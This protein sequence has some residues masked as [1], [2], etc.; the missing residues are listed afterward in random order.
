MK[1]FNLY[2]NRD[3]VIAISNGERALILYTP[4]DYNHHEYNRVGHFK[5]L[6]FLR[7]FEEIIGSVTIKKSIDSNHP[8]KI[9]YYGKN[10]ST[11]F[12]PSSLANQRT[13]HNHILI[14]SCW[15]I[16][17]ILIDLDERSKMSIYPVKDWEEWEEL[18]YFTLISS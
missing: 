1:A 8:H 4:I 9:K 11:A 7:D 5:S 14:H 6:N 3:G 18:D 13:K 17:P 10:A 2:K 12:L 16:N 15:I